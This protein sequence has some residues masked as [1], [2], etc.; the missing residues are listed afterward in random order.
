MKKLYIILITLFSVFTNVSL[1]NVDE[2]YL[3]IQNVGIKGSIARDQ[4]DSMFNFTK[5]FLNSDLEFIT[6]KYE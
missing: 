4:W 3:K 6:E 1:T 2:E 5:L